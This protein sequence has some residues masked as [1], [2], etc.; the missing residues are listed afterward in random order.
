MN[1]NKGVLKKK[2]SQFFTESRIHSGQTTYLLMS[3]FY[4]VLLTAAFI[5][6]LHG[7]HKVSGI[8]LVIV[9]SISF[10]SQAI[11]I[12][13]NA[14][15]VCNIRNKK[16]KGK[17]YSKEQIDG[18]IIACGFIGE[19]TAF[20]GIAS[21]LLI[22]GLQLSNGSSVFLALRI[23]SFL[24]SVFSITYGSVLL[25][26]HFKDRSRRNLEAFVKENSSE[27]EPLLAGQTEY[28]GRAVHDFFHDWSVCNSIIFISL[29]IYNLLY[30]TLLHEMLDF[31]SNHHTAMLLKTVV[32]V[33]YACVLSSIFLC[34][35]FGNKHR[36][37]NEGIQNEGTGTS[38]K[39]VHDIS[40]NE[41]AASSRSAAFI[42]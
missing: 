39:A 25:K 8:L 15:S 31:S 34:Q 32:F 3:V 23:F 2:K 18:F 40:I 12:T 4:L 20:L 16:D 13:C 26:K 14:M 19:S 17:G 1:R 41:G 38:V 5:M 9:A 36:S 22:L 21:A 10:L 27:K 33:G 30:E 35:F 37:S 6:M 11:N 29:G 24:A 7:E 28:K 42:D